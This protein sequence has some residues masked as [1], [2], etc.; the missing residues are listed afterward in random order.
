[1]NSL[2]SKKG[3]IIGMMAVSSLL[4]AGNGGVPASVM[5]QILA[6]K[7]DIVTEKA[8]IQTN[9]AAIAAINPTSSP[10]IGSDLTSAEGGF[11]G[12]TKATGGIENLI[13][14]STDNS[15]GIAWATSTNET[16]ETTSPYANSYHDG[17]TNTSAIVTQNGTGSDFAAGLCNNLNEG[18]KTDWYLPAI[19]E[20]ACVFNNLGKIKKTS[21][22]GFEESKYWGATEY[23]L[24]PESYA[25]YYYPSQSSPIRYSSKSSTYAVHCVRKFT[26]S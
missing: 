14:A 11:V 13:V 23:S 8:D 17:A 3:L 1:M 16:T 15:T 4:F 6:N 20:L 24:S 7:A 22:T 21:V 2:S 19:G 12:C 10:A 25:M 5:A 9:A 26:P 18:S